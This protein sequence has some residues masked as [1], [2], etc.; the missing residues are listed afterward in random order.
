MTVVQHHQVTARR[1]QRHLGESEPFAHARRWTMCARAAMP[2]EAIDVA[3]S[4]GRR[5]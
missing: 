3:Y 2:I 4:T 5:P 1:H